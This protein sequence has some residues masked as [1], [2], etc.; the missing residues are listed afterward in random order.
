MGACFD[1]AIFNYV[2][3]I[4]PKVHF[5]IFLL[6]WNK[7]SVPSRAALLVASRPY[8]SAIALTQLVQG[9]RTEYL[10]GW[11][12]AGIY[13]CGFEKMA[14]HRSFILLW[15]GY[16][17]NL[18]HSYAFA[19]DQRLHKLLGLLKRHKHP[20]KRGDCPTSID[21]LRRKLVSIL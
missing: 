14:T 3:F 18:S 15:S 8:R 17:W 10:R 13:D 6:I 19:D 1:E 11:K 4:F 21:E 7:L 2:S 16:E 12:Y 20:L 9:K 5:D